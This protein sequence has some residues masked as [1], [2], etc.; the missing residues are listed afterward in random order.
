[1]QRDSLDCRHA[2]RIATCAGAQPTAEGGAEWGIKDLGLRCSMEV[3]GG[4]GMNEQDRNLKGAL[5]CV[6]HA[7]GS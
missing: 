3:L 7:W 6:A 1:M 2:T 4:V 5:L